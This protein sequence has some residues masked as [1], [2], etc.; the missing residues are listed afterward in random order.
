VTESVA[1]DLVERARRGDA[2]AFGE[3][4]DLHRQAVYRAALAALR[5]PQEAEDVA[6]DAFVTAFRKLD[7]FRGDASFRT[8]VLAI[9]WRKALDRRGRLGPLVR[10]FAGP[11]SW[12]RD[13]DR[14]DPL[15]RVASRAPSQEDALLSSELGR[16]VRRLVASLPLKLRDALLLAGSGEYSYEEMSV[17]LG[18]P[19]GTIKWRVSEARRLLK[20]KLT[21]LGFTHDR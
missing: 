13:D 6:Q 5:S 18:A 7:S 19:P 15:D 11:Q 1:L 17:L 9:T 21:A 16:H 14:A 3:L 2:D 10:R 20:R 12:G 8:W 4:V